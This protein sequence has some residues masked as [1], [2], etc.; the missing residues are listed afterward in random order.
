M[1][2]SIVVARKTTVTLLTLGLLLSICIPSELPAQQACEECQQPCSETIETVDY[3]WW[4]TCPY[5][6]DCMWTYICTSC[7]TDGA[8]YC[9]DEFIGCQS[10][11]MMMYSIDCGCATGHA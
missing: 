9:Y 8:G 3:L 11:F 10:W 2:E 7:V 1:F 5:S 6:F 4:C